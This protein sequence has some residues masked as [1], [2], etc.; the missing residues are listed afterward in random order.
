VFI[1]LQIKFLETL[2]RVF[3]TKIYYITRGRGGNSRSSLH[4]YCQHNIRMELCFT[5]KGCELVKAKFR[6]W[7]VDLRKMLNYS[8][9]R[10]QRTGTSKNKVVLKISPLLVFLHWGSGVKII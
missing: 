8:M 6:N 3:E 4:V 7:F 2:K 9:G 10:C 1:I 5:A